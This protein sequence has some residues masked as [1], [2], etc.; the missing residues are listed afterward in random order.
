MYKAVVNHMLSLMIFAEK[1]VRFEEKKNRTS[2][3]PQI[4]RRFG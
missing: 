1:S 2:K 3:M 4:L